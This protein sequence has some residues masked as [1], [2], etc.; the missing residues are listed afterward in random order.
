VANTM[1]STSNVVERP[2]VDLP[3]WNSEYVMWFHSDTGNYG[4]AMV[5]VATAKTPCGPYTY[6]TSWQP[7]GAESR[8]EGLFQDGPRDIA[9]QTSYLLYASDNNQN[10]KITR[11]DANYYNVTTNVQ[12][13]DGV[14]LEAPGIVKR[15]SV[16][17]PIA[18]HTSGWA[19]NPNKYF[20][21]TYLSGTWSAQN[22][23][24]P[25]NTNTASRYFSQN[26][27]D[28]PLGTNAI[29]MGDRWR[30]DVLGSSQ[31]IWYPL[32]WASGVPQIVYADVWSVDLTAGIVALLFLFYSCL[33]T[34]ILGTYTV[35]TGTN[36]NV[37]LD[38]T[39]HHY[40]EEN[41]CGEQHVRPWGSG[42]LGVAGGVA[43]RGSG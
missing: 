25:E 29:C 41:I 31:Y 8:D 27:Y 26:A 22:D 1:I 10:F 42:T 33:L 2:K 35:A 36:S 4:A 6:K 39:E 43:V 21:S 18:S 14:T 30:V 28:L 11:L 3:A 13:L 15:D 34:A 24:T 37:H 7:L 19:A 40:T 23:L 5:G 16:Y 20:L 12:T 38:A 17:W 9:N 32:S